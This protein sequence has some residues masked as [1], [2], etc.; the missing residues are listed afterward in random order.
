MAL[1]IGDSEIFGASW[2]TREAKQLFSDEA[3]VGRW[4]E[5]LS[6]M[7]QAQAEFGLIPAAAAHEIRQYCKPELFAV[8]RLRELYQ[9]TGHSTAGFIRLYAEV[10]PPRAAD[11]FYFGATVQDVTDTS[12]SIALKRSGM[13]MSRDLQTTLQ[14]LRRLV[15][16][17]RGTPMLGRTHG[18]DGALIT[19]GYKCAVFL[20]EFRRHFERLNRVIQ[21][22]AVIQLGGAVGGLNAWGPNALAI[23]RRTAELLSLSDP[24]ISW[25]SSRDRLGEW[26]LVLNLI[27]AT[28][29]RLANEFYNLQRDGITEV[30]EFCSETQVSSVSMPHKRNPEL[31]EQIGTLAGLVRGLSQ[32]LSEASNHE[33]ER[34]GRG[35]KGEWACIPLIVSC[36]LAQTGILNQVLSGLEVRPEIMQANIDRARGHCFSDSLLFALAGKT[37]LGQ[38]RDRIAAIYK[39]P[40]ARSED[41]Q[42]RARK[43]CGDVISEE[44]FD[45]IFS[46]EHST[47]NCRRMC[48]QVLAETDEKDEG[49]VRTPAS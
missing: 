28:S 5:V 22:V 34:D 12:T 18:Q 17:H 41:L 6:A 4:L 44:D 31:C 36:F 1:F 33:H 11:Y 48:D 10:A 19:F 9:S 30:R 14:L 13:I 38:A 21:G 2:T 45:R 42:A 24:G 35:W 16:S 25:T 3:A 46:L 27:A 7:A 32:S 37:G 40:A 23:R 39:E 26:S 43:V 49:R 8:G 15:Q 20:S 47:A 29:A